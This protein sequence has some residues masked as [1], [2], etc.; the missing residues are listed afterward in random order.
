MVR[1]HGIAGHL[2][3]DHWRQLLERPKLADAAAITVQDSLHLE[4]ATALAEKGY[5]LLLEKPMATHPE[6][7]Q[8]IA[9]AVKRHGVRCAVAHVLRYT[10]YTQKLKALLESKVIGEIV[11]IQHLEPLGYWHQAHSYV[12]GHWAKEAE[13]SFMLLAKCCHDIDWL[14]YLVEVPCRRVS[15]FGGL[16][17]FHRDAMPDRA[18][19]RCLDCEMESSC[20]YSAKKIYLDALAAGN[21]GWPVSVVAEQPTQ[22][23]VTEALWTGPYGRCVY[24]CDNDVVDHQVVN[25]QFANGVTASLTMTGFSAANRFRKTRI[26]GTHGEIEGDGET[27]AVH[28]FL[29]DETKTY[30]MKLLYGEATDGHGGGDAGLMDA[31]VTAL[32]D[33]QPHHILSDVNVSLASHQLVFAA[34]QARLQNEVVTLQ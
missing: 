27:L 19:G 15:S 11:S 1:E 25:M 6:D 24:A 4:V 22:E 20:P 31:F 21:K 10:P 18:A 33:R 5:D 29:T 30:D 13:S 8:T 23:S 26:F 34:E 17:H 9:D 16:A 32:A 12:R 3:M 14:T 28:E 2:E 7:C